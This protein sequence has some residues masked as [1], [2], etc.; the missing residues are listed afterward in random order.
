[1]VPKCN[2]LTSSVHSLVVVVAFFCL[3]SSL[4]SPS[5]GKVIRPS[6]NP[7]YNDAASAANGTVQPFTIYQTT[8]V[9]I[10]GRDEV[11][12]HEWVATFWP[13]IDEFSVLE[14]AGSNNSMIFNPNLTI[15]VEYQNKTTPI[16]HV[17]QNENQLFIQ[18][19]T[20][21]VLLDGG[22]VTDLSWQDGCGGSAGCA[23]KYC[24]NNS[25]G[26]FRMDGGTDICTQID[27][28]IKVYWAYS[29]RD[30]Q[31]SACKSIASTPAKFSQYSLTQTRNF[32]SGLWND[33][34]YSFTQKAPNPINEQA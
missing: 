26:V 1:M 28:N 31:D 22:W 29:G 12:G 8:T 3:A 23:D 9:Y 15:W 20:A 17:Y 6:S 19:F 30:A 11:T 10:H 18:Y 2:T 34:I 24:L 25:C 27:C 5:F 33:V 14:I 4:I 13:R 16:K 7:D 32:G 21:V